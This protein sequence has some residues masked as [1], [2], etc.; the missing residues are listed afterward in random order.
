M[1]APAIT[2]RAPVLSDEMLARFHQRAPVYDRENHF[3]F[4]DFE[5]LKQAGYLT[6]N[7]PS[8]LGGRGYLLND[9]MKEQRRLAY[10]APATAVAINMHLY[11]VGVAAEL[12][13]AGD[14]SLEWMLRGAVNG[15]VYAAGHAEGG[16]D[17]PALLSTCRAERVDG[18]YRF[19]GRKS[20]GS[21]TPV[22]TYLGLH[23]MDTS[24]PTAPKI[25]HAF[26]PRSASGF[27]IQETWDTLGMRATRSDDTILDGAFVADKHI[28]RV[29]P[30]GGAG[31]DLFVL[32]IFAWGLIGFGNVYY[33][34]ARRAL[35][36]TL[37]NVKTKTSLAITRTMAY[38]PGV[39]YGVAD[40]VLNLEA[41]EPQ[42]DRTA[43][44][45]SRGVDH[46]ANWVI[47]IVG[48]KFNAV[49]GAWR[50]VDTAF[51]LGGGFGIFK[52]NELERLFRDA[53]LGRIHPANS[54]LTR[55]FV[56]KT[57]LGISPDES[58]RWG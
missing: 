39:Q 3:F 32:S 50:V 55:E 7:V 17:V 9:T 52:R 33:G 31:V 57:A 12:W 18:G 34:I 2:D 44:E 30:A 48:T 42:L 21:L 15:E 58:P 45:W 4:E 26:M 41:I 53:R 27:T 43:D 1:S 49:E 51:D 29:V 14:T 36:L 19:Y 22:W 25:I 54:A 13:R 6:M 37:A 8:E 23:G 47:K 38:H 56:A 46:G 28:G 20:F 5:E 40:M 35:D 11:W 16:N 24:D 10:Y